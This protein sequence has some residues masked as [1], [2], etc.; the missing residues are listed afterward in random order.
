M[1]SLNKRDTLED[2]ETRWR[3]HKNYKTQ[4]KAQSIVQV[5]REGFPGTRTNE[6]QTVGVN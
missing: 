2:Q 6:I 3:T 5:V 1:N 4:E